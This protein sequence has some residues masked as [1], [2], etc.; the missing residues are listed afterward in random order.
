MSDEHCETWMDE[1]GIT[2]TA[3]CRGL[4]VLV[5]GTTGGKVFCSM[6]RSILK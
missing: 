5:S 1:E 4:V 2:T 3:W 6:Q